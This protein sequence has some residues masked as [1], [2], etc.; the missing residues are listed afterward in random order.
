MNTKP[1]AFALVLAMHLLYMSTLRRI[2]TT[3]TDTSVSRIAYMK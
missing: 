3:R 2:P 1:P